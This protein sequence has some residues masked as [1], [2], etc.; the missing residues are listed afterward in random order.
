MYF[1]SLHDATGASI[2]TVY[3]GQPH[4]FFTAMSDERMAAMPL[5]RVDFSDVTIDPAS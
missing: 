2:F 3:P 4:S 5:P 1:L